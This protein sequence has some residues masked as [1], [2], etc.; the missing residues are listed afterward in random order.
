MVRS[1]GEG[2]VRRSEDRPA[3]WCVRLLVVFTLERLDMKRDLQDE[4]IAR[5]LADLEPS[6]RSIRKRYG[7]NED[8]G[9]DLLQDT[10][11]KYLCE[12]SSI[13]EP[14]AWILRV[15][16]NRCVS[17]IEDRI[18]S[19]ERKIDLADIERD[20]RRAPTAFGE[21][22]LHETIAGI[23]RLTPAAQTALFGRY[24]E[25]VP[26]PQLA[27]NLG[28]AASSLKNAIVRCVRKAR[29]VLRVH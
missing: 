22:L 7:I 2:E 14:R 27:D 18:R 13:Y 10:L 11:L 26:A 1:C 28:L 29:R 20:R 4:A 24:L 9:C 19:R 5:L 17:Y 6:V 23:E 12:E 8:A 15:F 16:R 21:V 25:E 3:G